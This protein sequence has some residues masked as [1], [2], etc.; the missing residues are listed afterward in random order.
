[1]YCNCQG[2]NV[3]LRDHENMCA[4]HWASLRGH[5]DAVKLLLGFNA[6]VNNVARRRHHD[7]NQHEAI[8]DQ[9]TPL[10]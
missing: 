3:R 8:A 2:A 1:M 7:D 6:A 4:L 9:F 10:G 5:M